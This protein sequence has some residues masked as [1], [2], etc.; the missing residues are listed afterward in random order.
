MRALPWVT[1]LVLAGCAGGSAPSP[2][3]SPTGLVVAVRY[4]GESVHDLSV[5][6][7]TV[8]TA[9]HF[10]PYVLTTATLPSGGTV[11]L[12]FDAGDAGAAMVC[13]EAHSASGSVLATNCGAFTIVA[14]E[15][16]NAE[17]DLSTINNHGGR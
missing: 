1:L 9:R 8:V 10:G 5:S 3:S 14:N 6:G 4:D 16:R 13:A 12:V 2:S 17:M 7:A 15:V 11:G